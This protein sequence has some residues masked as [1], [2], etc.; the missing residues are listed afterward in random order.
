MCHINK[1]VSAKMPICPVCNEG[2]LHVFRS[3]DNTLICGNENCRELV[4]YDT[5]K[6]VEDMEIPF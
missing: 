5:V 2:V 6:Y 3:R 4:Y 1:I